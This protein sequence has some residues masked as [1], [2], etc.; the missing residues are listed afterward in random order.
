M[1]DRERRLLK[2]EQAKLKKLI[3]MQRQKGQSDRENT[4][5]NMEFEDIGE[6]AIGGARIQ[7]NPIPEADINV[8]LERYRSDDDKI[9]PVAELTRER[10]SLLTLDE[11]HGSTGLRDLYEGYLSERHRGPELEKQSSVKD[12]DLESY[13]AADR[14]RL[15]SEQRELE[16]RNLVGGPKDMKTP[17]TREES[18]VKDGLSTKSKSLEIGN[19][20]A[21]IYSSMTMANRG[22]S[23]G[24]SFPQKESTNPRGAYDEICLE[25]DRNPKSENTYAFKSSERE[26]LIDDYLGEFKQRQQPYYTE[27]RQEEMDE[28]AYLTERK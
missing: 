12:T 22:T 21:D 26:P 13:S 27:K 11:T 15:D 23:R 8:L 5:V 24:L 6:G 25:L 7:S 19:T 9:T 10:D 1:S 17:T 2:R 28:T 20:G 14:K 4:N 16:G 18:E 3:E